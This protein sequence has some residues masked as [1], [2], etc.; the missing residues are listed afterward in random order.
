MPEPPGAC[1]YPR[2]QSAPVS[3]LVQALDQGTM[4]SVAMKVEPSS[5]DSVTTS[6]LRFKSRLS[7]PH[8]EVIVQG[9]DCGTRFILTQYLEFGVARQRRMESPV[10][11]PGS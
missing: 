2:N 10:Q 9:E 4:P 11:N 5:G 3:V 1:Q 8:V 7:F 6:A